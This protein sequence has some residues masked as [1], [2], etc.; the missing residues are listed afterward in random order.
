MDF[1]LSRK[2]SVI[3]L[4]SIVILGLFWAGC[5]E[6]SNKGVKATTRP[7]V[8]NS[9]LP[10]SQYQSASAQSSTA[11]AELFREMIFV[12]LRQE[13]KDRAEFGNWVDTLN[14]GASL[15]GVYHGLIHGKVYQKLEE[16]SSPA[17]ASAV[18]AFRDEWSALSLEGLSPEVS[19]RTSIYTLKR[20]LGER[21]LQL[22]NAQA[23]HREG[24]AQ[25]YGKWVAKIC[26]RSIDFGVPL[27]NRSD[28]AFHAQWAMNNSE[29]RLKWEVLNRLHRVLNEMELKK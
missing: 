26:Q 16:T 12:V 25:W 14:Q 2:A 19:Q 17:S 9:S 7:Q 11:H 5:T 23:S 10:G 13:P 24:L 1:K 28:E 27:R 6:S 22:I 3:L 8:E 20:L 4:P 15:E 29:D 21:A 18:A